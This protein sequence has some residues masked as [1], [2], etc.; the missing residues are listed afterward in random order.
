M[1]DQELQ[2][3]AHDI[4][5]IEDSSEAIKLIQKLKTESSLSEYAQSL[6]PQLNF[7]RIASLS[8]DQL[9]ELLKEHLLSAYTIPGYDLALKIESYVDQIDLVIDRVN[10]CRNIKSLLEKHALVFGTDTIAIKDRSLTANIASWI[11]DYN[12]YPL[13]GGNR[14]ALSELD[15]LNKSSNVKKL[16]PAE[17]EVLK[18]ILKLYDYVCN[19]I[20]SWDAI[21]TPANEK[22]A[23]Q[24]FDL[25][26][27]IPGLEE[28]EGTPQNS[29]VTS[30]SVTLNTISQPVIVPTQTAPKPSVKLPQFDAARPTPSATLHENKG[31]GKP[32]PKPATPVSPPAHT[33]NVPS[34]YS[35]NPGEIY[36]IINQRAK[37]K[38]GVV[39]DPTNVRLEEEKRRIDQNRNDQ[40]DVIQLKLTELRNRNKNEIK[41]EE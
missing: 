4:F 3:E 6:L 21:P 8:N 29:T 20:A 5:L 37:T 11:A 2:L 34:E 25:Y 18:N 26:K 40:A 36:D 19:F 22:E 14:G 13:K 28:D 7:I 27:F 24:D 30:A 33:M 35:A 38:V 39:M 16:E 15:Y 1:T 41:T 23:F 12:S 9:V 10:V 32:I 31:T 17:K